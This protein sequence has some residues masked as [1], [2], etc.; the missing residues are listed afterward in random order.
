[1]EQLQAKLGEDV[2]YIHHV[3]PDKLYA[4]V[5]YSLEKTKLFKVDITD[6]EVDDKKLS[7]YLLVQVE[8]RRV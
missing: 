6:L 4:L 1:M 3:D 5:A 7:A 2:V 8:K